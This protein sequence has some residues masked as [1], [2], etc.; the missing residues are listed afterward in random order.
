MHIAKVRNDLSVD[1]LFPGSCHETTASTLAEPALQDGDTP[2]R[3]IGQHA[4][5]S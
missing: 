4:L 3:P 2:M 5:A 1:Y